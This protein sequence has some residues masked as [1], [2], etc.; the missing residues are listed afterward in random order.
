MITEGRQAAIR[1]VEEVAE[2]LRGPRWRLEQVLLPK[3]EERPGAA[4]VLRRAGSPAADAPRVGPAVLGGED[5][6]DTEVVHP[7]V[8]E[9]YS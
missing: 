1:I 7:A 5:G 8:A 3:L 6:L 4:A 9:S 2:E